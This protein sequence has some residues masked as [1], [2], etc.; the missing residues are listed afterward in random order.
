MFSFFHEKIF[1]TKVDF[2]IFKE[3]PYCHSRQKR[4]FDIYLNYGKWE[5][6]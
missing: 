2:Q 1:S 4:V 5:K 6:N 3:T